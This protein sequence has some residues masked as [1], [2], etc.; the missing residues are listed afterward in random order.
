MPRDGVHRLV[1]LY[2]EYAQ[3]VSTMRILFVGIASINAR[4]PSS[5]APTAT[6]NSSH[7]GNTEIIASTTG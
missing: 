5:Q 2:R 7:K 1:G 6:T 3:T 4:V